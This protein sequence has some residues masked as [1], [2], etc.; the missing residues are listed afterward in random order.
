MHFRSLVPRVST[1]TCSTEK[2]QHIRW[3]VAAAVLLVSSLALGAPAYAVGITAA[4]CSDFGGSVQNFGSDACYLGVVDNGG[5]TVSDWEALAQALDPAFHLVS[6]HNQAENDYVWSLK[7]SNPEIAIGLI[8]LTANGSGFFLFD[9]PVWT[10]GSAVDFTNWDASDGISMNSEDAAFMWGAN[11]GF[12]SD[13]DD[14][15][16]TQFAVLKAAVV[17][18]PSTG[19]LLASGLLVVARSRRRQTR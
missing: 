2:S 15:N 18:E 1:A 7:G 12:W 3:F 17:P 5:N 6:I 13:I 4:Q 11:G 14:N 16:P 19:L 8:D 9:D 10:D